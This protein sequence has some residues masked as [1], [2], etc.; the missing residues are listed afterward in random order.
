MHGSLAAFVLDIPLKVQV[1]KVKFVVTV[2]MS[3]GVKLSHLGNTQKAMRFYQS[4]EP[5][6]AAELSLDGLV[7]LILS[8]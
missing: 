2:S 3:E 6:Q 4:M 8:V 7:H 5:H 1:T